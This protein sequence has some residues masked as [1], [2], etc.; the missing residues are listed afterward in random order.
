MSKK[1]KLSIIAFI[2]VFVITVVRLCFSPSYR[3][4]FTDDKQQEKLAFADEV[5][6][7]NYNSVDS[8]NIEVKMPNFPK[9]IICDQNDVKVTYK[10][11]ITYEEYEEQATDYVDSA[12]KDEILLVF[13]LENNSNL[14]VKL[15]DEGCYVNNI[16]L[17]SYIRNG[18]VSPNETQEQIVGLSIKELDNFGINNIN[19]IVFDNINI[20]FS[21][22][23]GKKLSTEYIPCELIDSDAKNNTISMPVGTIIYESNGIKFVLPEEPIYFDHYGSTKGYIFVEN[24]TDEYV[25]AGLWIVEEKYGFDYEDA[26]LKEA[27]IAPNKIEVLSLTDIINGYN[28]NYNDAFRVLPRVYLCDKETGEIDVRDKTFEKGKCYEIRFENIDSLL[29]EVGIEE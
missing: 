12:Y 17:N 7:A 26:N 2:I 5:I 16:R 27:I 11:A 13:E 19:N 22:E 4:E 9:Q 24:T 3:E 25:K 20:V 28:V 21:D 18:S 6:I 29:D 8:D 14:N 10:K 1:I 15:D 23:D